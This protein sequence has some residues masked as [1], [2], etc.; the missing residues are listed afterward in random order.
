MLR[1]ISL[2]ISDLHKVK[3]YKK[4]RKIW[5]YSQKFLRKTSEI[6]EIEKSNISYKRKTIKFWD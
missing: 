4:K 3:I 6:C 2:D 1:L 5:D